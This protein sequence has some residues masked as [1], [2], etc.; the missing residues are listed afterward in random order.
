MQRTVPRLDALP[1]FT[2]APGVTGR[3]LFGERSM[4][5]YVELAG[6]SSVAEHDHPHE[7][8]T[9][10]LTGGMILV[11]DGVE[12]HLGPLESMAIPS[13]TRHGG[14]ADEGGCTVLDVFTPI[15]DDFRER[16]AEATGT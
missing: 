5:N 12:H 10:I 9:V 7:Q 6:G 3:P 11:V 15:R 8:L 4:L 16:L 14:V 2:M 13:G 1:G